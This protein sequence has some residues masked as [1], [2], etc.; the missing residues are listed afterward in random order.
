MWKLLTYPKK[1][2]AFWKKTAIPGY[3]T[4]FSVI[5]TTDLHGLQCWA[6]HKVLHHTIPA[7]H[8]V[9]IMILRNIILVVKQC[10]MSHDAT[11]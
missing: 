6:V 3:T 4:G 5:N 1:M 8:S 2:N 9:Y 10:K 7:Q 11:Q